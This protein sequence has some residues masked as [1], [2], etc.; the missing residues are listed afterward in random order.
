MNRFSTHG[1]RLLAIA[2]VV[3]LATL[4]VVPT[5]RA[6]EGRGGDV[7]VIEADEVIDDDL[8]V[9]AGE[10]RLDGTVKG[11]LFVAGSTIEING[12][13]E[14]DLVAAGQSV[15]VDG[16]VE[17]D[18]RI[19]GYTLVV[20]GD[21]ADD[22]IAVG[23]SLENQSGSNVG[24]DLLSAGYQAVLA[25][26]VTGTADVAGGAVEVAGTIGGNLNV[27]VGGAEPGQEMPPGFPFFYAPD[28]PPVPSVPAG[29]TIDEGARIGGDLNYT[30]NAR[31]AIP[32]GAVAGDVDFTQY[33][34]EVEPR[35]E[36]KVPSPAALVGGW[37]VRQLRR[38]I[39]L[40]L[41]GAFMMWLV[42]GWTR[43]VAGIVQTRPLPSLGWGVV[44][45]AAFVFAML[46]LIVGTVLLAVVFGVVT[47]G[48]LAGRFAVLGGI[49]MSTAGFG[50]SVTWSYVTKIVISLLLGQLIFTLFKSPAAGNRWWP[51]LLGVVIFVAITAIPVLGWLARLATVLLGLGAV[52]LWARD[53]LAA[54][55]PAPVAVEAEA[56][57]IPPAE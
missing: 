19:A 24:G 25:G 11:D 46:V 51:V 2:G 35:P 44:A 34:P 12:T 31:I 36:V 29:L 41:V 40:L 43:K 17:D 33:V 45:I 9:G 52:W 5:A 49:V 21:V 55:R 18:A 53:W 16:T 48:E 39:T 4:L 37:F 47:L 10:F 50:F 57:G 13:V 38:L 32:A 7:V 28:V 54:R 1:R 22:L 3:L 42:P 6:L 20:G 26:A 30:A 8:Y 15:A 56:G 23:F 14:G 27:D